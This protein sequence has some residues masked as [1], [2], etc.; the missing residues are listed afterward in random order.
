MNSF[1]NTAL[2]R[3]AFAPRSEPAHDKH[4]RKQLRDALLGFRDR[5]AQLAAEIPRN[6]PFFTVH[7]ITHIDALW[8]T[9]SLVA[10]P[11]IDLTPTEGFVLGGAI[12]VHDLAMSIAA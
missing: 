12:L 3:K 2:W 6:H 5:S 4:H 9:A 11:T 1:E 10:G 8:E 7:D